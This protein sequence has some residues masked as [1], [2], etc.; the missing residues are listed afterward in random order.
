[1]KKIIVSL[2]LIIIII[3][4]FGCTN[5]LSF[6][7]GAQMS[8]INCEH[9]PYITMNALSVYKN[10]GNYWIV[11]SDAEGI[12]QKLIEFSPERKIG[13]VQGLDLLKS[14]DINLFLNM[15]IAELR[16]KYGQPH[17]DIG[18]GFYIPA[19][20]TQDAYLICLELENDIVVEVVKRDILTNNIVDH[21][22]QSDN[23]G[24][25]L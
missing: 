8:K 24:T 13:K 5:S 16:E 20:I 18:S 23:Q 11:I 17:V 14:E 10:N 19:Y 2:L 21:I 1:M 25:V 4:F 3:F 9:T 7:V 15:D 12:V 6:E 22:G